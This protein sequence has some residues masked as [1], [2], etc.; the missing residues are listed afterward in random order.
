MSRVHK[1]Y[2]SLLHPSPNR[3]FMALVLFLDRAGLS[4]ENKHQ[5]CWP[6]EYAE[7]ESSSANPVCSLVL[8]VSLRGLLILWL[9]K[10]VAAS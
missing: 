9:A 10:E 1:I 8:R 2:G 5:I 4:P 6:E 7:S 3:F